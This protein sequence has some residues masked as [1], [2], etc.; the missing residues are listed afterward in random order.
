MITKLP[1]S[2]GSTVGYEI[3]GKID[4]EAESAWIAEI[5]ENIKAHGPISALVYLKDDAGWGVNAGIEDIKWIMSHL[6]EI[7]KV[8][9]VADSAAWKWLIAID[10]KFAKLFGIDEKFFKSEQIDAA[11]VWLKK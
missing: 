6:K 10:S 8:A 1:Q 4:T 5:A 3:S 11:W 7:K 9:V 2:E